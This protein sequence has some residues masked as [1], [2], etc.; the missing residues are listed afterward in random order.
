MGRALGRAA[1]GALAGQRVV[2]DLALRRPVE[3]VEA[4][5]VCP[6]VVA[7]HVRPHHLGDACHPVGGLV[8]VEL[9]VD[10]VARHERAVG[11]DPFTNHPL[12]KT[13]ADARREEEETGEHP[14]VAHMHES[15]VEDTQSMPAVETTDEPLGWMETKTVSE[16]S[17]D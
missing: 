11:D 6:A 4:Q 10:A 15:P 8:D 9:D 12:F 1:L 16:F 3:A 5:A 17:W 14:V 2:D 13:E 7:D